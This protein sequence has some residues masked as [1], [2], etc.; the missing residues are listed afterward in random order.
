MPRWLP[1]TPAWLGALTLGP[2]GVIAT[3]GYLV[4][5]LFGLGHLPDEGPARGWSGWTIAACGIVAFGIHGV[6][7]GAAAWSYQRRTRP[8]CVSR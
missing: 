8:R 3:F 4:P 1:L 7:L 2:Y 6:A 5:P